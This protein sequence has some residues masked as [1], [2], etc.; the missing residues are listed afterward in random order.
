[1]LAI[2]AIYIWLRD[3]ERPAKPPFSTQASDKE[4]S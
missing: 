2:P 3:D 4:T 1:L